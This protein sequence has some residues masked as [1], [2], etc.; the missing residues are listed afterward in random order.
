MT[1]RRL[2]AIALAWTAAALLVG[3][4]VWMRRWSDPSLAGLAAEVGGLLPFYWTWALLTPAVL[5]VARRVRDAG[6]PWPRAVA[7]HLAAALLVAVAH[8]LVYAPVDAWLEAPARFPPGPA[9]LAES[10]RHH[11]LGHLAT[12]AGIVGAW[13]LA[14]HRLR[15]REEAARA[16]ELRAD[17]GQARL[18][19]LRAQI[20]PHF[21][22]NALNG[23]TMLVRQGDSEA[24]IRTLVEL[25]AL[26]RHALDDARPHL[27]PLAEEVGTLG[28]YLAI[29]S[30]RFG[31]RLRPEIDVDP[32]VASVPVPAFLLQPLVENAIRHGLARRRDAGAIRIEARGD[33]A[34]GVVIAVWNAGP[35]LGEGAHDGHGVGLRNTRARLAA[36]YGDRASLALADAPGGVLATVRLPRAAAD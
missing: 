31:D 3:L 30:I 2:A 21:L 17:L 34:G 11:L 7:A 32:A 10:L 20:N 28:R 25:S 27:V 16:A 23:A 4:H 36:A 1:R 14:V 22:F 19:A 8:A 29:E 6:W 9:R 35:P 33:G 26:L 15:A 24:A 5:A 18:D 13:L 12:Y